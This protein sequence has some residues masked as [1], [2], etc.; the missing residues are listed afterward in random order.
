MKLRQTK[1]CIS[2]FT[3]LARLGGLYVTLSLMASLFVGARPRTHSG[4]WLRLRS[5][6]TVLSGAVSTQTHFA[7]AARL[8]TRPPSGTDLGYAGMFDCLA[9]SSKATRRDA[10]SHI[11]CNAEKSLIKDRIR[12]LRFGMPQ[13]KD[14]ATDRARISTLTVLGL[15]SNDS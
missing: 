3:Q 12:G 14:G 7:R 6:F 2:V 13:N 4:E 10:S 8:T 11:L 15:Q 5:M 1:Q 9:E